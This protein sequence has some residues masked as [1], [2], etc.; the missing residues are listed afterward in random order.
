MSQISEEILLNAQMR[1]AIEGYLPSTILTF[2]TTFLLYFFL[3]QYTT[4]DKIYIEL[5]LLMQLTL[6]AT[7]LFLYLRYH[8]NYEPIKTIWARWLEIPLNIGS[9]LG[10]GL[11]WVLFIDPD[12]LH[13]I[14]LLNI[15][16]SSALFVY[17]ISTPLHPAATNSGLFACILPVIVKSYSMGGVLFTAI[18]IGGIILGVSVYLFGVELHRLHLRNLLQLEENK[19]LVAELQIE[20]QQVE[21]ISQEKTRF[22]AAASHDLR[23]PI[24]A[25]KLFETI[26]RPLLT[27]PRQREILSKMGETNQSLLNLLDPL[28]ELSKLDAGA[29]KLHPEW[30]YLDD[31]LYHIQQQYSD[32]A[33]KIKFNFD[34]HLHLNRFL[35]ILNN[36][37]EF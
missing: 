15:V 9:G 11:I 36:W 32:L 13:T 34:V 30:L 23:Q 1:M 22:L 12:N 28:L 6:C 14:I 37:S 21:E 2:F 31:L 19:Q 29:V 3:A 26:L 16:T 33:E 24:Q 18:S 27:E 8:K 7:W 20:K 10:W 25:L 35:R 4:A 5:W 17:V